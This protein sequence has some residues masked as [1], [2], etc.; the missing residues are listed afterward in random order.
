M[1]TGIHLTMKYNFS[2][3]PSNSYLDLDFNNSGVYAC[4]VLVSYFC[5]YAL[6]SHTGFWWLLAFPAEKWFS[7]YRGLKYFTQNSMVLHS[8]VLI[9]FSSFQKKSSLSSVAEYIASAE[10]CSRIPQKSGHL[11]ICDHLLSQYNDGLSCQTKWRSRSTS[12]V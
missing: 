11:E 5:S 4:W 6:S 3:W 8:M 1:L 12:E 10:W 9:R 7:F 2:N